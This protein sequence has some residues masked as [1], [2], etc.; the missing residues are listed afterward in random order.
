VPV[1]DA[2]ALAEAMNTLLNDEALRS[3]LGQQAKAHAI[4]GYSLTAMSNSHVALYHMLLS[5]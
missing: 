5:T 1:R 4:S 3:K 2:R